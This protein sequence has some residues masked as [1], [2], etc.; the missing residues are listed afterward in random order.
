MKKNSASFNLSRY[1]SI[2]NQ[3]VEILFPIQQYDQQACLSVG[4]QQCSSGDQQLCSTD[5]VPVTPSD[6]ED[7]LKSRRMQNET[8]CIVRMHPVLDIIN[9]T[10]TEVTSTSIPI[11]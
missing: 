11:I 1:S 4:N 3:S 5:G 8:V 7:P 6:D 9:Q 2:S 10:N